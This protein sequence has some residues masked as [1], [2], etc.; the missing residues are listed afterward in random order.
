[1]GKKERIGKDPL[2]WIEDTTKKKS[3]QDKQS[4]SNNTS[5]QSKPKSTQAG[6]PG[7]W[8]RATFIMREDHLEK[9]KAVAYWDRKQI[10]EVMEEA[11]E[12]YLK[13]KKVRSIPR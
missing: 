9:I 2:S 7:G 4:N 11:I 6:L 12:G 3:K 8:S 10:K 1:M 13:V 5:L